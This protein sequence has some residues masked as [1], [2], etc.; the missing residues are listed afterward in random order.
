[1][2]TKHTYIIRNKNENESL[3]IFL[4]IPENKD[5][6]KDVIQAFTEINFEFTETNDMF[7]NDELTIKAISDIGAFTI[8]RDNEDYYSVL[9][10]HDGIKKLDSILYNNPGFMKTT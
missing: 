10:M 4:D 8:L 9:G 7:I 1:M 3:L 5:F 6:I 2:E